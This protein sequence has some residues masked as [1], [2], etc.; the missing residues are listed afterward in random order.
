MWNVPLFELN[1]DDREEAAVVEV[2]RSRW[3]T[4][5]PRTEEFERKFAAALG[6]EVRPLAV[7]SC[8]AA[9]HLSLLAAGIGPG[10]EVIV[11][12][13]SFVACLNVVTLS[14]ATPVLADSASLADWNAS[15]AEIRKRITGK[16]RAIIVV[17]FAG[18]PCDME[19]ICRIATEHDLILIEDAAHAVGAT[20]RGRSCGTLG[21]LGC[22]S[23]FSNKNLSTG[24]G[25]MVV[26]RNEEL[27]QRLKLL[28]SHG[29]TSLTVER[30]AGKS[31]SYDVAL[32]GLNYRTDEI[33]SA[34]GIVQLEKLAQGNEKRRALMG[35]YRQRLA[36]TGIELPWD[37][38]H[39]ASS[40][41]HIATVLLPE[42]CDRPK[43]MEALRE[44]GIQTSIH[45]PA[46]CDF[47]R[48]RA[49]CEPLPVASVISRRE[50]TL[51]LFPTM[52]P[53]AVDLV[54]DEL[55]RHAC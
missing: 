31:I 28:R 12:A 6:D 36:G 45:Y 47:S 30:H 50:L 11:S 29:M 19:E 38:A 54:C 1:F 43:V 37:A 9:L 48:Y 18:Y 23:F 46:Y 34:I 20:Y 25:G 13:L 41:C 27:Y 17:H 8:T 32:A 44:R 53:G 35:Q 39:D 51:P 24:E 22:F 4:M 42:G 15:P 26:T 7:S 52:G 49:T 16:T 40:S 21:D 2:L 10:D 14:G 5:G 55:V 3:L 33:H